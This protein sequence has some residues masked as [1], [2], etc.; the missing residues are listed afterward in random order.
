MQKEEYGKFLKLLLDMG[1]QMLDCG[2]E[3]Y[4]VEQTVSRMGEYYGAVKTNV[5]AISSSIVLTVDFGGNDQ[6]TESRRING[7]GSINFSRIEGFNSLSRKCEKAPLPLDELEK[8]IKSISKIESKLK[9]YIGS[10]IA[11]AAFTV[12]FGGKLKESVIAAAAALLI[13]VFECHFAPV[14]PNKII[15]NFFTSL[16]SGAAICLFCAVFK[17]FSYEK[18]I[19]G[20]LMLLIPGIAITN[21]LRDVFVGDTVSG[22]MRFVES[23]FSTIGLAAG[24]MIPIFFTGVAI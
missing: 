9:L 1:E 12:F 5:F 24:F 10:A 8:E 4:R 16:V 23:V 7:T 15:F 6:L 11:A 13:C 2:A 22:S 17:S 21:A 18:I 3:I 14:C 20:D 19:M